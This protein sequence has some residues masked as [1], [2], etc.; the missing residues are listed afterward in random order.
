MG[1]LL[2]AFAA[3]KPTFAIALKSRQPGGTIHIGDQVTLQ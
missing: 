1:I 2:K 3:E